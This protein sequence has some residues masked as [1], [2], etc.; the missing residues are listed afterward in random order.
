MCSTVTEVR[1]PAQL[2]FGG[3]RVSDIALAWLRSTAA[4]QRRSSRAPARTHRAHPGA[5]VTTLDWPYEVSEQL[6]WHW[7]QQLRPR[8]TG[9]SDDEYFWEPTPDSWSV[10]PRGQS[11]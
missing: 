7:A 3:Q 6:R 8:L 10:H 11:R 2:I 1:L 5:T 4:P 9:L